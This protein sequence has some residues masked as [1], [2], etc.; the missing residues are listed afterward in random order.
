MV[1]LKPITAIVQEKEI[2]IVKSVFQDLK[3]KLP[4]LEST[5][6]KY[7]RLGD[8][9]ILSFKVDSKYYN[10]FVEKFTFNRIKILFLEKVQKEIT[11][12]A[13]SQASN[14][15]D[16]KTI[17][18]SSLKESKSNFS[19]KNMSQIDH[20]IKNGDYLKL[21]TLSRDI[22]QT[23]DI[24][25]KASKNISISIA[26]AIEIEKHK[27]ETIKYAVEESIKNLIAISANKILKNIGQTELAK[28]AGLIA[29]ELCCI[30]R[31]YLDNLIDIANN[32]AVPN[33]VSIKAAIQLGV[34]IMDYPDEFADDL[35]LAV[36]KL[37]V[38][39][40]ENAYDVVCNDLD[41]FEIETFN[42]FTIFLL[43][44]RNAK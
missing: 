2:E 29:V 14:H 43:E 39:W 7:G 32:N 13:I 22:S 21:I 6:F 33:I 38:R 36:R 41:P 25:E 10:L 30:H 42:S 31:K 19:Q 3:D 1:E 16:E 18:W 5:P 44:K 20:Y 24:I 12:N 9:H 15:S 40:L 26:N 37:N 34:I 23:T 8:K 35:A 4:D 11:D 17:D 27:A 28:N